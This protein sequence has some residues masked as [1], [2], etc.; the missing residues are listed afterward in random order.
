MASSIIDSDFL[1]VE[2][3]LQYIWEATV[4]R[5]STGQENGNGLGL[6]LFAVQIT[7][8]LASLT[9]QYFPAFCEYERERLLKIQR[10]N[11]WRHSLLVSQPPRDLCNKAGIPNASRNTFG[12]G[13]PYMGHRRWLGGRGRDG[14]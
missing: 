9:T 3:A 11:D 5:E 14:R 10:A 1:T 6:E 13:G 12:A 7:I 2:C 8:S 4:E